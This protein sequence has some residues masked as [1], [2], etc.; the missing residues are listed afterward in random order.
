MKD[1]IERLLI[2]SLSL[3]HREKLENKH[4]KRLKAILRIQ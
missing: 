3:I 1:P 2:S 4:H